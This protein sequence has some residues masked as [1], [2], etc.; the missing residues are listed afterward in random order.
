[1]KLVF[2]T[3]IFISAIVIPHSKAEKAILKI[4]EG[5]DTLVISKDIINE[6]LSVLSTKFHRDRE[7][8]SHA[9]FYLSE[10]AQIVTPR[11]AVQVFKDDPDNR[12]LECALSGKAD[13]IVTG[14]KEMLKLKAFEGIK[15]ISLKEYLEL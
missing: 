8:I 9:A 11:K 12:I 14:D 13:A 15:I 3:N 2:D 10:L 5:I 4:I 6:I 7:A 1:M